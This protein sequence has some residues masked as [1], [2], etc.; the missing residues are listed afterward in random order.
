MS[1]AKRSPDDNRGWTT[2][3]DPSPRAR[4]SQPK[5]LQSAAYPSSQRGWRSRWNISDGRIAVCCGAS[6]AD[7]CCSTAATA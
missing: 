6:K 1:R 7:F 3:R 4:A 2:I 5:A